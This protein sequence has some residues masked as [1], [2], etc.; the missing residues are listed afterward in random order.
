MKRKSSHELREAFMASRKTDFQS[1]GL[2]NGERGGCFQTVS[3]SHRE[4]RD[5]VQDARQLDVMVSELLQQQDAVG[6]G[7]INNCHDYSTKR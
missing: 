2:N 5:G 7:V 1:Q 3:A 6:D 4:H